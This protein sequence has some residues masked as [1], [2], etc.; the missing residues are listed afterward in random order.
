MKKLILLFTVL[1]SFTMFS[2][3]TK[4][5]EYSFTQFFDMIKAEQ[6]TVFKLE[7]ALIKYNTKTDE[8][9]SLTN[10]MEKQIIK[11]DSIFINKHLKLNNVHFVQK[12]Q[13]NN[14]YKKAGVFNYISFR[15]PIELEETSAIIFQ[16][17]SFKETVKFRTTEKSNNVTTL[18]NPFITFIQNSFED[19]FS[20]DLIGTQN[21]PNQS[22]VFI[23]KN[24]FK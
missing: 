14:T 10:K 9:F 13:I 20:F 16:F 12:F 7:N 8:R 1:F 6:D 22:I 19:E 3:E 2:Q 24:I 5:K 15:K 11:R 23:E 17:C 18:A 21:N 4:I